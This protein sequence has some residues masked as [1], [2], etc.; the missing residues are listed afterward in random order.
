MTATRS[1]TRH[2]DVRAAPRT[3]LDDPGAAEHRAG[4][5]LG[6]RVPTPRLHQVPP[7]PAA[8]LDRVAAGSGIELVASVEPAVVFTSLASHAVAELCNDCVIDIQDDGGHAYR[9]S[10][11]PGTASAAAGRRVD[12][13][14]D[15]PT[16]R[17]LRLEFAD[18]TGT[19][20]DDAD[21]PSHRGEDGYRGAATF[22]WRRQRPTRADAQIARLLIEQ[23]LRTVAWQRSEQRSRITAERAHHLDIA[24]QTSRQIGAAIGIL[25]TI[26]KITDK[27]AFD[28][29]RLAS[30]HSHRKL[31]DLAL[32]VIDTGWLDAAFVGDRR[33]GHH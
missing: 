9:L 30:Q 1:P 33:S 13:H 4:P 6:T 32:D 10:Y 19:N 28:L 5:T 14:G 16:E 25:M 31:R 20:R 22:G 3:D 24:L 7:L 27:D 23:A 17:T 8:R 12:P 2:D 21:E 29:L 15:P 26:H 11:P 18:P